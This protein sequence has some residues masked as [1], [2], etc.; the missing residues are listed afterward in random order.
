MVTPNLL[1][2][3]ANGWPQL[4][5]SRSIA[6]GGSGS[7]QPRWLFLPYQL[8]LISPN[9]VPVWVTGPARLFSARRRGS[10]RHGMAAATEPG[11]APDHRRGRVGPELDHQ[12]RA[13]AAP[14]PVQTMAESLIAQINYDGAERSADRSSSTPWPAWSTACRCRTQ[15]CGTAD[16][17]LRGGRS[18][19]SVRA[20]A[21]A[22]A[23]PQRS[24]RL[25]ALG[26]RRRTARPLAQS[27]MW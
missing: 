19:R 9:L 2:Q 13:D 1:W 25:R 24:Q 4:T 12:R 18:H 17:Q 27:A 5:L 11:T 23:C 14:A 26:S 21:R 20:R 8:V 3:N 10:G 16:R 7:S 22:S 15:L 6:A